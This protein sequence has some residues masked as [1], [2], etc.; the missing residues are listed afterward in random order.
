MAFTV[1]KDIETGNTIIDKEHVE[2]F[3]KINDFM[4]ACNQGKG[5]K[6]IVSTV[7]FLRK[8]TKSHFSNEENLQKTNNYPGMP[9]HKRFHDEFIKN[10]DSIASDLQKDGVSPAIVG[11]I[12][13]KIGTALIAH[14]KSE[15]VKLAKFLKSKNSA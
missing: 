11:R 7:D 15:D 1:T 2:L 12:N 14:I 13:I 4:E 6:E 3:S 8:Y 9:A 10:L 5:T